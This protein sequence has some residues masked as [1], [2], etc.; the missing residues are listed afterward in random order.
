MVCKFGDLSFNKREIQPSGLKCKSIINFVEMGVCH[1]IDIS[2]CLVFVL[3]HLLMR[4][5]EASRLYQLESER[6][7]AGI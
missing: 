1:V 6:A 3:Q 5:R 4:E 7:E 2:L